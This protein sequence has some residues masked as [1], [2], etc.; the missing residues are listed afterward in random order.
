VLANR[1]RQL[2]RHYG[3]RAPAD[4][5]QEREAA[6][7]QFNARARDGKEPPPQSEKLLQMLAAR[8]KR[9]KDLTPRVKWQK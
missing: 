2:H 8:S 4:F 9:A 7:K 6:A 5:V 1:Q 3:V